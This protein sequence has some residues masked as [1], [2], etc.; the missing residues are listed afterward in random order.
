MLEVVGVVV[1]DDEAAVELETRES[2]AENVGVGVDEILA[3]VLVVGNLGGVLDWS[4]RLLTILGS[5]PRLCRA[6]SSS[7]WSILGSN[8][9]SL[10]SN[11][12]LLETAAAAAAAEEDDDDLLLLPPLGCSNILGSNPKSRGSMP[13]KRAL[14][15]MVAIN[16]GSIITLINLGSMPID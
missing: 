1:L 12:A 9:S 8:P 2:R 6:F 3:V 5:R 10:G 11:P 14:G 15:S 13:P 7:P 4:R 16:L